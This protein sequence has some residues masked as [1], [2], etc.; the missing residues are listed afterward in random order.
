LYNAVSYP[1][2]VTKP[3]LKGDKLDHNTDS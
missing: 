2:C 1:E 3:H